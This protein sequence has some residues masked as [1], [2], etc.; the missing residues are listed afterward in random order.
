MSRI[1]GFTTIWGVTINPMVIVLCLAVVGILYL[2]WRGQ[3]DA[4]SNS[5]DIWDLVMDIGPDGKRR[6]SSIKC[7]FQAAFLL[8]S[9]VI[10]D[11]E[12][13]GVLTEAIFGLYL[14]TWCA[15]L[16]AKVVYDKKDPPSIPKKDQI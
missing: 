15:S 14:F 2:L 13:K 12:I 8:S 9:W 6:A 1:N 16:I 3:R 11:Q 10:V 5:F 4:G 7:C